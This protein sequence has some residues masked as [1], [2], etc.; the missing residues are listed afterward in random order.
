MVALW[1]K[2]MAATPR[3]H[4]PLRASSAVSNS[5]ARSQA[6]IPS[7]NQRATKT[8]YRVHELIAARWHALSR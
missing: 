4:S 7:P 5:A 1:R 3:F 6:V 2:R 8:R